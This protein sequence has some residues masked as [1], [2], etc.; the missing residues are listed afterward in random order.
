MDNKEKKDRIITIVVVIAILIISIVGI[1][2]ATGVFKFGEAND[3]DIDGNN[4]GDVT[5]GIKDFELKDP[6]NDADI[7]ENSRLAYTRIN[8]IMTKDEAIKIM[9]EPSKIESGDDAFSEY[10]YW[11]QADGIDLISVKAKGIKLYNV[12]NNIALDTKYNSQLAKEL[13][14][15]IEDISTLISSINIGISKDEVINVLG[16]KYIEVS[17]SNLGYTSCRWYDKKENYIEI[18]FDENN[19]VLQI[20]ND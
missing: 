12:Y 7:V 15:E 10:I 18:E 9:G 4:S 20:K 1:L 17:K 5:S 2:F 14:K 8:P 6:K 13:G 19:K 16:D 11:S 3:D